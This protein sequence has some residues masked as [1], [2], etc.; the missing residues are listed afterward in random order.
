MTK[1]PTEEDLGIELTAEEQGILA[2]PTTQEPDDELPQAETDENDTLVQG[3]PK[4]EDKPAETPEAKATRERDEAGKFVAKPK[5]E[6]QPDPKA[7]PS[8]KPPP[9]YTQIQALQ[10]ERALRR[11]T[12]ERMQVLL[13]TLQKREARE[14][15]KDEPAPTIPDKLTDPLGYIDYI[16]S[17]LGKIEGETAAQ[18]QARQQAETEQKEVNDALAVALPQFNEAAAADPTLTDQY[19]ALLASMAREIAFVNGIPTNGTITPA[20]RD[21]VGRELTKLEQGHIRFAV[22]SG[23]NVAEYMREFASSRGIGTP[24]PAAATPAAP[25][26]PAKT[27]AER[28]NAQQRHMSIGDLPGSAAPAQI[29]AKDLVKMT[30]AEFA[31]FAKKMGDAGLDEMFKNA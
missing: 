21:F 23:R 2:R 18:T 28:A 12:E 3:K 25:A 20:Q 29:S 19:N 6:A 9:G 31:A 26:A 16:E 13:E 17:R 10:E 8:A 5:D 15:K 4:A 27:I 22:A 1:R 14:A 30:P 24:A 7:D 11:Q